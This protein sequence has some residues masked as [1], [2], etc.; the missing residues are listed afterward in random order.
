[1]NVQE[2]LIPTGLRGPYVPDVELTLRARE[3]VL[4]VLA[5]SVAKSADLLGYGA[6]ARDELVE[7]VLLTATDTIGR[8]TQAPEEL[9]F[10]V[11]MKGTPSGL[12][13]RIR[14]K[15]APFDPSRVRGA[16]PLRSGEDTAPASKLPEGVLLARLVDVL[17]AQSLGRNG[18]EIRLLKRLDSAPDR[19]SV[20]PPPGPGAEEPPTAEAVHEVRALRPD[21]AIQVTQCIH[22][23]YGYSYC[24]DDIYYPDRLIALNE[25]GAMESA[26]A[27]TASGEVV[28]HAALVFHPCHTGIAEIATVVVRRRFRGQ[29]ISCRLGQFLVARARER[30][31][32]GV[33]IEA[34][35]SHVFS[36]N[37]GLRLGMKL[38]GFLLGH[39]PAD[40]SFKGL[41]QGKPH[42]ETV[43]LGYMPI[44]SLAPRTVYAPPRHAELIRKLYDHLGLA[45]FVEVVGSPHFDRHH[46]KLSVRVDPSM[47]VA[48][49]HI[50]VYGQ[51]VLARIR[52]EL[53]ALR[54]AGSEVI[55]VFLNLNDPMTALVAEDLSRHEFLFTGILPGIET[56]DLMLMQHVGR[57]PVD[58]DAIKLVPGNG[59]QLLAYI[60]LNDP[61]A[62]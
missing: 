28:G 14:D 58:Y 17:E 54:N 39:A 36:Q 56:G 44:E 53:R 13:V 46:S 6:P 7:A 4:P 9:S 57:V 42:R 38:S 12:E 47:Q 25:S 33:F 15:G 18:M 11:S 26:V 59:D 32:A 2:E 8:L 22:D 31:L 29:H 60:R 3:R 23:A 52:Q 35:T 55:E 62:N 5:A 1:M 48:T 51:D 24:H 27:V 19:T 21:D 49:I 16:W 20:L 10:R 41:S 40:L 34:V 61:N 45:A 50:P 30:G 37:F 43:V